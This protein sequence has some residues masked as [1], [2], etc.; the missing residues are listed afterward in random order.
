M[1]PDEYLRVCKEVV[2]FLHELQRA[3]HRRPLLIHGR[4]FGR[5]LEQVRADGVPVAQQR[6][7]LDA[8]LVVAESPTPVRHTSQW[9][10]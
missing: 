9:P 3:T 7:Q 5:A 8:C 4:V 2:H 6:Q 10:Y 1:S